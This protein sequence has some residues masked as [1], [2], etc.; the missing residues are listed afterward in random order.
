MI[1]NRIIC[2]II[3]DIRGEFD[4]RRVAVK[5]LLPECF[6]FA[7]REVA[8]LRESDAHPHVIR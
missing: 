8:L 3:S 7:D 2:D 6:T 4:N 5:R 1:Y